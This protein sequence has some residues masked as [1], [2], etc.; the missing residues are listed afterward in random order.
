MQVTFTL[1]AAE[2][3][4]T[5]TTLKGRPTQRSNDRRGYLA[6]PLRSSRMVR[7]AWVQFD[8]IDFT[9]TNVRARR[10]PGNGAH[11]LG[12]VPGGRVQSRALGR[13]PFAVGVTSG[14]RGADVCMDARGIAVVRPPLFDVDVVRT[15]HGRT[16]ATT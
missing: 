8:S 9:R 7:Q 12:I 2:H 4:S 1:P 13:Q 11:R 5:E 10:M 14:W 16:I 15:D 3:L 6:F